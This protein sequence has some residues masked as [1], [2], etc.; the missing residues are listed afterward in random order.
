MAFRVPRTR[1]TLVHFHSLSFAAHMD[2]RRI[3]R[4]DAR[5]DLQCVV[6]APKLRVE[7]K[8]WSPAEV[9]RLQHRA[10]EV[11]ARMVR[12]WSPAEEIRLQATAA[13]SLVFAAK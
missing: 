2:P 9:F 7:A 8:I 3:A 11:G 5:M 4:M 1:F 10:I 6:R 13:D 12:A